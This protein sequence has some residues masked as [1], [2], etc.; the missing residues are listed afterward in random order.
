MAA[1]RVRSAPLQAEA[2]A[3]AVRAGLGL[4]LRRRP[5]PGRPHSGESVQPGRPGGH[6]KLKLPAAVPPSKFLL[7]SIGTEVPRAV[8]LRQ[9]SSSNLDFGPFATLPAQPGCQRSHAAATVGSSSNL[10][11]SGSES[12]S[13]HESHP[14]LWQ[15]SSG[16]AARAGPY[17]AA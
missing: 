9:P 15:A 7:S 3:A 8:E 5:P 6:F 14:D 2:R 10:R 12:E 1:R 11:E 4:G 17:D 13:G 16:A